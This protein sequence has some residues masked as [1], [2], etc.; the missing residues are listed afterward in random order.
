MPELSDFRLGADVVDKDGRKAGSLASVLVDQDGFEPKAI[1]IH[2]I[3]G[4][5]NSAGLT[6][7]DARAS[8]S[9]HYSVGKSGSVLFSSEPHVLGFG[10]FSEDLLEELS[11]VPELP[12]V[13]VLPV[14]PSLLAGLSP[15]ACVSSALAA[16]L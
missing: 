4:S 8:V 14:L 12:P 15:L 9:A 7:N 16:F 6:F 3:V 11:D 5:L 2:I 13:S 1:V 10:L